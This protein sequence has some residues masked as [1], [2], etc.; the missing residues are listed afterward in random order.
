MPAAG[1]RSTPRDPSANAFDREIEAAERQ[2]RA[3]AEQVETFGQAESAAAAYRLEQGL[4]NAALEQFGTVSDASRTI[5]R[6]YA[7]DLRAAREQLEA[8]T[9]AQREQAEAARRAQSD[10]EGLADSFTRFGQSLATGGDLLRST[11][12]LLAEFAGQALG[13]TGLIGSQ[14]NAALGQASGGLIGALLTPAA[15]A[16]G[17]AFGADFRVGGGG[18]FDS[19]MLRIPV[20][21]GERVTITPPG[22]GAGFDERAMARALTRS[23]RDDGRRGSRFELSRASL[24]A[25]LGA[26]LNRGGRLA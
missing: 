26:V 19:R 6:V 25:D 14:V 3:T 12:S 8:M 23:G 2:L 13:G 15:V 16:P 4:L 22:G 20:T 24:A 7:D 10:V 1:G 5:A 18:G 11:L 21:P 9:R 17:A